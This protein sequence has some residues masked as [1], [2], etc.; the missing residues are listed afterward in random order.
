[1]RFAAIADIHGN[2]LALE[3]VIADIRA[4]RIDDV[5][6]LG[7]VVSGPFD[8]R[9][10]ME[11]LM[12]LDAVH[13]PRSLLRDSG[14]A[15]RTPAG[16]RYVPYDHDAAAALARENRSKWVNALSTGWVG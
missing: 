6:N 14:A 4:Q 5:V 12:P 10:T 3:A 1:M 11:L 7:D 2:Y 16:F 9:R 15:R 13:V 8:A